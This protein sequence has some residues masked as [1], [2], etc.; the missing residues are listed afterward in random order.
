MSQLIDENLNQKIENTLQAISGMMPAIRQEIRSIK[1][2]K[3][4]SEQRIERTLDIL[5]DYLH[6][7]YGEK[8]FKEL[9]TYYASLNKK[10]ASQY[11]RYFIEITE[12]DIPEPD[13]HEPE[14]TEIGWLDI[15][16]EPTAKIKEFIKSLFE[17]NIPGSW[18]RFEK[19]NYQESLARKPDP[20]M[21]YETFIQ[22]IRD[23][24]LVRFDVNKKEFHPDDPYEDV[25][26][27]SLFAACIYLP[28]TPEIERL[29]WHFTPIGYGFFHEH[30]NYKT[31]D[32]IFKN[33][34]NTEMRTYKSVFTRG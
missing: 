21:Q 31:I 24:R 18:F 25:N 2:D 1:N 6:W 26:V 15:Q 3:S 23:N 32:D 7:G 29:A 14:P 11:R 13:E 27:I 17:A 8:E 9:N 10:S 28:E 30:P 22:N 4:N 19:V 20:E 16:K 34:F 12:I 33:I 5:I